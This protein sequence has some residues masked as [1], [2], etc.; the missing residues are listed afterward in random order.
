MKTLKTV[1][2]TKKSGANSSTRTDRKNNK[3]SNRAEKKQKTVHSP[4][5]TCG[6][7]K[8]LHREMF[9]WSQC[10]KQTA[11]RNRKSEVQNQVQ[12]TDSQNNALKSAQVATQNLNY[13]SHV[14]IPELLLT[15]RRPPEQYLCRSSFRIHPSRRPVH[16]MLLMNPLIKTHTTTQTPKI[17]QRNDVGSQ[18]LPPINATW[19]QKSGSDTKQFL[20]IETRSTQ[21]SCPNNSQKVKPK[22]KRPNLTWQ[23][24]KMNQPSDSLDP[25]SHCSRLG[26]CGLTQN[27][28]SQ[29]GWNTQPILKATERRNFNENNVRTQENFWINIQSD[30]QYLWTSFKINPS[31]KKSSLQDW[32]KLQKR[33]LYPY[34]WG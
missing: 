17:K 28:L 19:P 1:L 7:N 22:P 27:L 14:F 12:Q 9:P 2:E 4:Y 31:R 29:Y 6:E 20:E 11:S 21:V 3:N 24:I 15:D 5:D 32:C 25:E 16:L 10:S 26:I 23:S 18:E 33:W 8:L 13:K 30:Q 34:D